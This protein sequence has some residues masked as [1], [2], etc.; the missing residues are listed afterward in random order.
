MEAWDA[1]PD[2]LGDPLLVRRVEVGEQEA[3]RDRLGVELLDRFGYCAWFVLAQGVELAVRPHAATRADAVFRRHQGRRLWR[4]EPVEL[5][6]VL[7]S[8][9]QDVLEALRRDQHCSGAALF[10]ECVRAHGHPVHEALDLAGRRSGPLD[11]RGDRSKDALRLVPRSRGRLCRV[12]NGAVKQDGVGE[13][14]AYV[15]PE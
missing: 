7:A 10:E 11:H 5:R 9:L 13:R 1:A 14:S 3:D 6:A 4:A 2:L 15:D 8:D 12:N